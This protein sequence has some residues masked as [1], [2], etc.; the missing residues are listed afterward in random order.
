MG[1]FN[2]VFCRCPQCGNQVCHQIGPIVSGFGEFHL[3]SFEDLSSRTEEELRKLKNALQGE[4]FFCETCATE[5]DPYE[6]RAGSEKGS[7]IKELLIQDEPESAW[8]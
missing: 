8:L 1:M 3:D 2:E 5:F 7:L 4:R 6:G